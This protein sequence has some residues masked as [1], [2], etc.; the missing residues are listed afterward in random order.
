MRITHWARPPWSWGDWPRTRAG[1]VSR[2]SLGRSKFHKEKIIARKVQF[3]MPNIYSIDQGPGGCLDCHRPLW[4][5]GALS[6][7]HSSA[8]DRLFQALFRSHSPTDRGGCWHHQVSELWPDMIKVFLIDIIPVT[9]KCF[10]S[11]LLDVLLTWP[12]IKIS[13]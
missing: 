3:S 8:D 11:Q 13:W 2:S 1:V 12:P 9:T 7:A 5:R 6:G 4:S 10:W